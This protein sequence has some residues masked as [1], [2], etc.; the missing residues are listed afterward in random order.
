M[1]NTIHVLALLL[2]SDSVGCAL[3]SAGLRGPQVSEFI[4]PSHVPELQHFLYGGRSDWLHRPFR[5]IFL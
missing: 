4:G 1:F 5:A 2:C 3:S